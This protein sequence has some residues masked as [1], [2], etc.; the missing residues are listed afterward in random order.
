[1][2]HPQSTSPAAQPRTRADSPHG[3]RG[4]APSRRCAFTLIELLV[5]IA[6]IAILIG[7]LVPALG[8]ARNAARK[9]KDAT[10]LRSIAQGMTSWA[11]NHAG[12]FPLPSEL[13]LSDWTVRTDSNDAPLV[14]DNTGNMLSVLIFNDLFSAEQARSPVETNDRI[15]LDGEYARGN[16][17]KAEKAELALWD[18]GFA[19]FPGEENSFSGVS[20]HGRR[21]ETIGNNS[22]ALAFPFGDRREGWNGSVGAQT[23]LA[24]NRGPQYRFKDGDEWTLDP[25]GALSGQSN[26]LRFYGR[27][28]AWE[29]HLA[30]ADGHAT[31]LD[32]PNPEALTFAPYDTDADPFRDNVFVNEVEVA[33][34]AK[35]G[36]YDSTLDTRPDLGTNAFIR[37]WGNLSA[38]AGSGEVELEAV[39][40]RGEDGNFID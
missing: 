5:V 24:G 22:Y 26:T 15:E 7:I 37:V 21:S 8:A 3:S 20:S 11:G 23:V 38:P 29:G 25:E 4:A 39:G 18:P 13:D 16:P 27:E 40:Q 33:A 12:E 30:F 35:F 9:A 34:D 1:M 36:G 2:H 32:T 14:K 17:S 31:F 6:I 10:H 19:G 28:D